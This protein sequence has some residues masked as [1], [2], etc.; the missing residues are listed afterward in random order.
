M[1]YQFNPYYG[2]Q[3]MNMMPQQPQQQFQTI[4]SIN[5]RV[6]PQVMCYFVKEAKDLAGLKLLPETF[7]LGI[8]ADRKEIYVRKMNEMGVAELE[9][10]TLATESKEKSELQI[11]SERLETIEKMLTPKQEVVNGTSTTTAS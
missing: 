10:Y 11:I 5:K 8:N 4:Q 1:N 9:A 7:Y 2:G 3:P 6:E